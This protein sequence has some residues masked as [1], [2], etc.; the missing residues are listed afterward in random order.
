MIEVRW[1]P[2]SV[3]VYNAIY[4]EHGDDLTVFASR[5]ECAEH[6]DDEQH[7]ET[8]WGFRGADAA[9]IKNVRRGTRKQPDTTYY[10]AMVLPEDA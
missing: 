6:D 3:H 5:T 2:T 10:I 9:L 8:H 1:M 7:I 4:V